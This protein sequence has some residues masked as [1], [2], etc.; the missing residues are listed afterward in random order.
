MGLFFSL[1]M[2]ASS[3]DS[4]AVLC[5]P[6]DCLTEGTTLTYCLVIPAKLNVDMLRAALFRAVETKIPRAGARLASNNGVSVVHV[7]Y[8][9]ADANGFF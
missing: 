1:V 6:I 7:I 3:V 2:V 5:S 4:D 9:A 8:M